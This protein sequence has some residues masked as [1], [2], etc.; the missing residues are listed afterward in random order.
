M[1]SL[2]LSIE[3]QANILVK[4]FQGVYNLLKVVH[5]LFFNN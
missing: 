5:S 2:L 3:W 1:K 4:N